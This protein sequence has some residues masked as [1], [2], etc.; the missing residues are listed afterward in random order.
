MS[1][2]VRSIRFAAADYSV[3][4]GAV[5]KGSDLRPT[6]AHTPPVDRSMDSR[7]DANVAACSL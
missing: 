5:K 2:I 4:Q 1:G 6:P 3:E 7:G